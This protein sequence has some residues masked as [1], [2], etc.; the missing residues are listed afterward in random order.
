MREFGLLSRVRLRDLKL[1][2]RPHRRTRHSLGDRGVVP[3]V[4]RSDGRAKRDEQRD[5]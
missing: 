5:G 2:V 3:D 4:L 1:T